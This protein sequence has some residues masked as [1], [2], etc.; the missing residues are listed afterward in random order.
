MSPEDTT[1]DENAAR[2]GALGDEELRRLC[3]ERV[4]PDCP[5]MKKARDESMRAWAETENIKKRLAREKDEF[6]KFANEGVLSDLLPVLDNLDLALEHGRKLEGCKDF[7]TGVE[8]T[9]RVL[10]DQLAKHGL[11]SVG[12]A[13]EAFNPEVHEAVGFEQRADYPEGF[14][15][16]LLQRGYRLRGRLLRPARVYVNKTC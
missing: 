3:Q 9:R 4:C 11:E 2:P 1:A 10:L 6:C 8:M 16:M 14:V 13:G 12:D 5:E 15:C 7:L